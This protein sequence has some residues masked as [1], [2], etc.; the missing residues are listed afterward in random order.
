MQRD[1]R[2]LAVLTLP[3]CLAAYLAGVASWSRTLRPA[4]IMTQRAPL[5][6]GFVLPHRCWEFRAWLQDSTQIA[7][8]CGL[9][10]TAIIAESAPIGVRF[11]VPHRRWE[12]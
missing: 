9:A 12:S 11:M 3:V 5:L 10:V 4:A 6:L 8:V 1:D 7:L 2:V